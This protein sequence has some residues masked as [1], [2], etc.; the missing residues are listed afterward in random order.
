MSK[1]KRSNIPPLQSMTDEQLQEL[2][3]RHQERKDLTETYPKLV[4]VL[5]AWL[6]NMEPE[7]IAEHTNNV[8]Q[9]FFGVGITADVRVAQCMLKNGYTREAI[10]DAIL[11]HQSSFNWLTY[12]QMVAFSACFERLIEHYPKYPPN[13]FQ[14]LLNVAFGLSRELRDAC[15]ATYGEEAAKEIP[16]VRI[17]G[18]EVEINKLDK[19][20]RIPYKPT[21]M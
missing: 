13:S 2:L 14:T 16:T 20:K 3:A 9:G 12:P 4:D 17:I 8:Y 15:I 19:A 1:F 6:P 11:H 18:N 10:D 5:L 21:L 7:Q